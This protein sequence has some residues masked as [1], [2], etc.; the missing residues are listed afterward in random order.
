MDVQRHEERKV[1]NVRKA[2]EKAEG[3]AGAFFLEPNE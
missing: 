3:Y 1:L 2:D